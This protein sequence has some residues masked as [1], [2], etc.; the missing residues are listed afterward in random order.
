MDVQGQVTA[1]PAKWRN[2][3]PMKHVQP[4]KK[5][6]VVWLGHA[7]LYDALRVLKLAI[8]NE[9]FHI[10]QRHHRGSRTRHHNNRRLRCGIRY[11]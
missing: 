11:Y 1:H 4:A 5:L 8:F 10:V 9:L 7:L 2:M 3:M 6:T